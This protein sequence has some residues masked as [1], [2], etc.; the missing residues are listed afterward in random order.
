MTPPCAGEKLTRYLVE[1]AF[2]ERG[3]R[4]LDLCAGDG[5]RVRLLRS[6][7]YQA[8]GLDSQPRSADV[9]RGSFP[10]APW[11]DG[12]FNGILSF[13]CMDSVGNLAVALEEAARLLA[14]GG[15]LIFCL[16]TDNIVQLLSA[17]R[18]A[19]FSVRHMEE[20]SADWAQDCPIPTSQDLSQVL[21]V[22]ERM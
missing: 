4:W 18:K 7:G 5:S 2:L 16:E 21:F 19:G 15:K 22:C 10:E 1:L 6:L 11:A 3:S 12:F 20:L 17:V 8:A 13:F 14:K 9:T